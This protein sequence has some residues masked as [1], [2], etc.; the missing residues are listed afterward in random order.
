[1]NRLASVLAGTITT[2]LSGAAIAGAAASQGAFGGNATQPPVKAA[3]TWEPA[4][5]AEATALATVQAAP[6]EPVQRFVYVDK[7]PVIVTREIRIPAPAAGV[8]NAAPAPSARST[9]ESAQPASTPEAKPSP[10]AV[11]PQS[12]AS[13]V[14]PVA[15]PQPAIA[16]KSVT[17]VSSPPSVAASP[18]ASASPSGRPKVEDRESKEREEDEE[19]DDDDD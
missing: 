7:E 11:P 9:N 15:P 10:T 6:Q 18:S 8:E 16:A 14:T 1:M 3:A 5:T 2:A 13:P 19:D 17:P 12:A 4:A